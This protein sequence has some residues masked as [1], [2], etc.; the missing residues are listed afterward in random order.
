MNFTF[1]VIRF[2]AIIV[3]RLVHY[4]GSVKS[5]LKMNKLF[6]IRR[7]H[8]VKVRNEIV[9]EDVQSIFM[10]LNLMQYVSF[11]PK[12]HIKNNVIT[13]NGLI[14]N[15]VSM[16]GTLVF[17]FIH[18]YHD[19]L[20]TFYKNYPGFTSFMYVTTLFDCIFYNCGNVLNFV[21]GII[22][23]RNAVKFVLI[24]QNVHRFLNC[25]TS[26]RIFTIWNWIIVIGYTCMYVVITTIISIPIKVP[27]IHILA[28][29]LVIFF[30]FNLLYAVR[31]FKLLED[32][33][34]QWNMQVLK[35]HKIENLHEIYH[36]KKMLKAY[37]GILECYDIHQVCY[38][39]FV[40]ILLSTW[41][42][43]LVVE[44]RVSV[45]W[46]FM[47]DFLL[48]LLTKRITV[49]SRKVFFVKTLIK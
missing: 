12:Y 25:E 46:V 10:P 4:D 31:I 9:D 19:Y 6:S 18:I 11:C 41:F 13:P 29:Y 49:R 26:T 48:S 35:T 43:V 36:C 5:L 33:I 32:Q 45:N 8:P 40:S 20:V 7:N 27:F 22:Q 34:V 39:Q 37:V 44:D 28:D 42:L 24:Y 21:I 17:I 23:T 38:Q 2:P 14:S 30:D 1:V 16:K 3:A 47:H 15:F